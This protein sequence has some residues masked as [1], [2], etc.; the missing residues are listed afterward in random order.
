[1]NTT[2]LGYHVF[3][4]TR[5]AP[6]ACGNFY[7]GLNAEKKKKKGL[8]YVKRNK[9]LSCSVIWCRIEDAQLMTLNQDKC[10]QC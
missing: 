6:R 1:M 2:R 8:S 9:H 5:L 3:P 4:G 7:R 10:H